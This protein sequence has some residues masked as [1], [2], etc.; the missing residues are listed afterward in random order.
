[1][2]SKPPLQTRTGIDVNRLFPLHAPTHPACLCTTPAWLRAG[3]DGGI[4]V[5]RLM[6]LADESDDDEEGGGGGSHSS[7]KQ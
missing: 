6:E 2:S 3:K 5:N 1:M 4:D 7:D